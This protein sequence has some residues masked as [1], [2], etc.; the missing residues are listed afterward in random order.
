M[1]REATAQDAPASSADAPAAEA[2][3]GALTEEEMEILVAR[4]ALYPDS[5]VAA[6]AAASLYPL[7]IV[8]AER[9][10]DGA[11][12]GDSPD[13]D[14]DG[15]VISLLNTPEIVKM[16]SDDL[17]WTGQLG[18]AVSYQQ[19][20]VLVAIQQL[21]SQAVADGVI[22]TDQHTEVVQEG[23][24]III[25]PTEVDQVY[26]PQYPPEM[27][28]E[29]DY[30]RAPVAYY[31]QPY[32]NY[33][34]PT[35]TFF[36]GVITGLAWGAVVDWDD[37]GVRGGHW[38]S[39][40]DINCRNCFNNINGKVNWR[41]VDWTK[42]DR[43]KIS[44][45]R[46][47][48]NGFDRDKIGDRLDNRGTIGGRGDRRPGGAL[49]AGGRPGARPDREA[50]SR[51]IRK[52]AASGGLGGGD[53][54]G[55]KPGGGDRP[56]LRPGGGDKPGLRPGGGDRPSLRPGG[57]DKP[58]LKPGG[59][60]DRPA[61]KPPAGA[62]SRPALTK[63]SGGSRLASGGGGGKPLLKPS[64]K[65]KLGAKP[66]ASRPRSALGSGGGGG[67]RAKMASKRG[68]EARGGGRAGGKPKV[69]GRRGR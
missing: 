69:G 43:D 14:W 29:P 31:P 59:G 3:D 15:S 30:V 50:R 41:D 36:T 27:L 57:G 23:D 54:P 34:L 44:I 28:Y 9:F 10:L 6:I 19:Q 13:P 62:G 32:P 8:E 49:G 26:V 46:D 40:V 5:L 22:Q 16:M 20:D 48:F 47:Q 11:K 24:T 45:D 58:G 7:Q 21:R 60:G 63:P 56:G 35:A 61:L 25:Q 65:P 38:D 18:D 4:I 33:Y 39:D 64:G 1:P 17:E 37:W 66:G 55:L 52:A 42:V 67:T 12:A 68:A 53:R 2:D 51:D